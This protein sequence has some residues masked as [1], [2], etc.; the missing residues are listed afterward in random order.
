MADKTN[1]GKEPVRADA[2]G[3]ATLDKV[4]TTM[5]TIL[6]GMDK[7]G[8]RF[9]AQQAR[10]DSMESKIKADADADESAAK[11]AAEKAAKEK[12]DADAAE[13]AKADAAAAD[14]AKAD[15]A[16]KTGAAVDPAVLAAVRSDIKR[17]ESMIPMALSDADYA[18][19]A[20]AQARADRVFQALGDSAPRPLQGENLLGYRR[21]LATTLKAHSANW[22]ASDLLAIADSAAFD[23]I[24]TQIYADAMHAAHNPTDLPEGQLR[25]LVSVDSTGRRIT[26]FA[27]R[28]GSW[29]GHFSSNRRV[30]SGIGRKES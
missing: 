30:L 21:R 18:A 23:V 14:A 16:A 15:A 20:D 26:T 12:A 25:P 2:E 17:V 1:D 6:D 27:G 10:L 13:K 5:G 28:P 8:K 22:K 9:D 4:L 3:G 24:E 29:M 11:E 7:L 19:M